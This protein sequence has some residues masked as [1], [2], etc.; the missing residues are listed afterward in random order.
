M[1]DLTELKG[2]IREHCN[3]LIGLLEE[4]TEKF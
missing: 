4:T 2:L 1:R 3:D